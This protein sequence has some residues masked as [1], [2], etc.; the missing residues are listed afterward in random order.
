MVGNPNHDKFGRFSSGNVGIEL[1]KPAGGSS[2]RASK[3]ASKGNAKVADHIKSQHFA[4]KR[5]NFN[6]FDGGR[7]KVDDH[8]FMKGE[9]AGYKPH[10]KVTAF[11]HNGRTLYPGQP[12]KT[13]INKVTSA[14]DRSINV[15]SYK[16]G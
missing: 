6:N 5:D 12:T 14:R 15:K 11:Q 4:S 10:T 9:A 16:K 1:N 13:H 2:L 8:L 7:S 3:H